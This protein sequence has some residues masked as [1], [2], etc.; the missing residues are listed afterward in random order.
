MTTRGSSPNGRNAPFRQNAPGRQQS[1]PGRSEALLRRFHE[2][3]KVE[4]YDLKSLK[5]IWPY[6]KPHAKLLFGSFALLFTASFLSVAGPLVM[7]DGL[8]KASSDPGA[9]T[10]A[11]LVL[12]CLMV[13]EQAIAFPQMYLMQKAGARAMADLRR[14][15]FRFLHTRSLAFFDRQPVGRLVTRVTNDVDAINEMFASGALNAFGDLIR[16]VLIIGILVWHDALMALITFA[17]L[18]LVAIGVNYTRRRIRDAFREVRTKTSRMNAYLNEQVN[19]M[20]IVQAYAREEQGAEEF[21]AINDAYRRANNRSIVWDATLDAAIELVSSICVAAVL[22]AAG[23]EML[24]EHVSF[25]TLFLF[26]AYIDKFFLPIRDL[27]ARY[28]LAQ[29]AV[30]GAERVFELLDN[31]E[32]DAPG[33]GKVTEKKDVAAGETV[34]ELDHVTFG[35]KPTVDVLMDV[36]LRIKK[37]ERVALVGATGAGKSTVA[38]LFLRLYDV[39]LGAVRAFGEDVR[40]WD[41]DALRSNFAVVP[42]DVFLFPGTVA[43]NV[44]AG[45]ADPDLDRVTRA[46]VR[47]GAL[48]VFTRREEGLLAPVLERGANFSAGERQLIAFARALYRDPEIV[49]LDEAT[50]SVDSDTESK[51]QHAIEEMMQNRTSLVIAHRLSTIRA[52]D[53]IIVFHKGRIVEEGTHEELL[54]QDGVYARLHKLQFMKEQEVDPAA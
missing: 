28:T 27:S 20:A 26:V 49:V 24:R 19:G 36:S 46:L 31:V 1:S 23:G 15:V 45:D 25:G 35:Y 41:R 12:T 18:P 3:E 7:S 51:L 32:E 52:A 43:S 21:D 34:L 4:S 11:G 14:A 5:R 29:S 37:G 30:T 22:W 48:D 44:A 9:I 47:I 39:K 6:V 38:S 2:E 16:L 50:A 54:A 8:D 13:A 17:A 33:G 40:D 42:Q 10:R 53:R